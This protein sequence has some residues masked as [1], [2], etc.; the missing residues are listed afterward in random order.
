[1]QLAK[2]IDSKKFLWDGK[3]YASPVDAQAAADAYAKDGFEVRTMTDEGK[4]VVYNRRL[5][6]QQTATE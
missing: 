2:T 5:A 6:A 4:H 1:M 3:E